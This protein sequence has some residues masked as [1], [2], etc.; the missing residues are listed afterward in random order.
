MDRGRCGH[1]ENIGQNGQLSVEY[2]CR[3]R[4]AGSMCRNANQAYDAR[5]APLIA[6]CDTLAHCARGGVVLQMP[7]EPFRRTTTRFID[8]ARRKALLV[9]LVFVAA[10]SHRVATAPLDTRVSAPVRPD[11]RTLAVYRTVADSIYVQTT[12]RP[13]AVVAT[14]LDTACTSSPCANVEERWGLA[15]LW[16]AGAD[17]TEA[18]SA[19]RSLLLNSA[20][21]FD[22]RGLPVGTKNV[23][24]VDPGVVPI[25]GS[26]VAPW[27]AFRDGNYAA[28]GAL[29]F[30]RVGFGRSGQTAIVFVDWRCG[31]ACG[32]TLS[33]AL[34]A[35]SD[36][37]WR[38]GDML[39]LSSLQAR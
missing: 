21:R 32:H 5:E 13:I 4:T 20:M 29:Q 15:S 26:D 14:T 17:S 7:L 9:A 34:Q 25:P 27:I 28:A 2:G 18:S 19:R 39:L 6:A 12:A 3:V 8:R 33:V 36:S 22:L 23:V 1:W 30:S 11:A 38:I 37:T 31:P 35:T 10:C 24:T 16:W